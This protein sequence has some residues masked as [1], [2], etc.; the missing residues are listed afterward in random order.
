MKIHKIQI[1]SKDVFIS[2][3]DS[4]FK[5]VKPW[6]KEDGSWNW[7][8]ILTGGSWWN[9]GLVAFAVVIILGLLNEYS[10]NIGILQETA[11]RCPAMLFP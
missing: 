1:D 11:K 6:K 2:Q 5:V 7:F 9:L 3:R 10:T 4:S 8:N